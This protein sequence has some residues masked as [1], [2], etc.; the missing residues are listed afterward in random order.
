M[1]EELENAQKSSVIGPAVITRCTAVK[2]K[3]DAAVTELQ[4]YKDKNKEV[5][6]VTVLKDAKQQLTDSRKQFTIVRKILNLKCPVS[7]TRDVIVDI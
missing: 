7:Q 1:A 5:D 6:T 2:T 4:T 3:F